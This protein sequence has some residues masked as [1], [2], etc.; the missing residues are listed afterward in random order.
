M[1]CFNFGFNFGY[2]QPWCQAGV[3]KIDSSTVVCRGVPTARCQMGFFQQ[4]NLNCERPHAVMWQ[5]FAPSPTHAKGS[6]AVM[7]QL[8]APTPTHAKG[9]NAVMWQPLVST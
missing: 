8:F 1:C 7:W 9:S 2:L 3:C 5:L 4:L 6:N